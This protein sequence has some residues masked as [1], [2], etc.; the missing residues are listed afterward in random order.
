MGCGVV[1]RID[2]SQEFLLIEMYGDWAI[3]E[4]QLPAAADVQDRLSLALN[5]SLHV[6]LLVILMSEGATDRSLLR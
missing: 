4:V 3:G 5:E 6:V 1:Y 2:E